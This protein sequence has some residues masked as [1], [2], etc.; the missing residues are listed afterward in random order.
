LTEVRARLTAGWEPG[1][2]I[3]TF[4]LHWQ[5]VFRRLLDLADTDRGDSDQDEAATAAA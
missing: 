4:M 5:E 1:D 3:L 2:W